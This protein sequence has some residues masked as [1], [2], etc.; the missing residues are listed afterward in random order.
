[1]INKQKYFYNSKLFTEKGNRLSV[2]GRQIG[3]KLEIW[4]LK[5]S[6]SDNY[7]R[8]LARNVYEYFTNQI[9]EGK[10]NPLML[11]IIKPETM[12]HPTVYL[13]PIKEGNSSKFTF[14]TH[15]KFNNYCHMYEEKKFVKSSF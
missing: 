1:M 2:F 8:R 4:E 15:C 12:Y 6:K 10:L 7:N 14:D 9:P 11:S 5:C 3:N 13:I